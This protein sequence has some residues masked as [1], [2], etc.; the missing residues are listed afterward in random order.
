VTL[1]GGKKPYPVTSIKVQL[2]FVSVQ[3]KK[4]SPI[5]DIKTSVLINNAV[6]AGFTLNAAEV[7]NVPFTLQIPGG[8][9]PSSGGLKGAILSPGGPSVSY[10][11]QVL[12]EISGAKNPSAKCD[13]KVIDGSNA[14]SID[15]VYNRWPALRGTAEQPLLDALRD[16]R[17]AHRQDDPENDLMIAEPLLARLM[18]DGTPAVRREALGAWASVIEGRAKKEHMKALVEAAQKDPDKELLREAVEAGGRFLKVGAFDFVAQHVTHPDADVRR[19]VA[20][21]LRNANDEPKARQLLE[22][23][24]VDADPE[25]RATAIGGFGN[26]NDKPSIEKV[27]KMIDTEKEEAPLKACASALAMCG[28]SGPREIALPALD[29]LS[30]HAN[31]E[32]R[33][34]VANQIHCMLYQGRTEAMP[35]VERLLNDPEVE[36]RKEC[37]W[38]MRN[39]MQYTGAV[40]PLLKKIVGSDASQEVRGAAAGSLGSMQPPE[41]AAKAL[42]DILATKPSKEVVRGVID[43][44]RFSTAP[45]FK[46]ILKGLL[47][48]PDA[49]IARTAKEAFEYKDS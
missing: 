2:I 6:A 14:A 30:K 5:P 17:Y 40:T 44:I 1:T 8:T 10:T 27:A 39:A 26:S 16:L 33:K 4:D 45:M 11:V 36:V 18:K 12:A 47:N 48:Y 49:D 42:K 37:A 29:K 41:E 32:V 24:L 19:S 43:G 22:K 7:K 9:T 35:V 46:E 13:L 31:S 28:F 23:M 15:S 21:G 34:Q 38:Y 3:S 25:V 20:S